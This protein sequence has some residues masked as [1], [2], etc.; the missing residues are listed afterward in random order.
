M[1]RDLLAVQIIACIVVTTI[2]VI[3]GAWIFQPDLKGFF[4][5]LYAEGLGAFATIFI[6]ERMLQH[7]EI[8]KRRQAHKRRHLV[9]NMCSD[10]PIET[11][12]ALRKLRQLGWLTEGALHNVSLA[13]ANLREADLHEAD[14]YHTNLRRALLDDAILINADLRRS[15]LAHARM[16]GTQC[17]LADLR[18]AN[19]IRVDAQRTNLRSANLVGATLRHAQLQHADMTDSDLQGANLIGANLQGADLARADLRGTQFDVSTILPD[20]SRWTSDSDLDR[21]TDPRHPA[22][23]RSDNPRSPAHEIEMAC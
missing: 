17:T 1:R 20:G 2:A 23:W 11:S 19:L 6:V 16:H 21:F 18:H 9:A 14:L 12:H 7:D 10:D 5:N 13:H 8:R 22:F 15:L 4:A 3:W